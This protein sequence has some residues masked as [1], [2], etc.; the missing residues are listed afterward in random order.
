MTNQAA[1]KWT[2]A[3]FRLHPG[4]MAPEPHWLVR[5]LYGRVLLASEL[6]RVKPELEFSVYAPDDSL[7]PQVDEMIDR[8]GLRKWPRPS[9]CREQLRAFALIL[10][11]FWALELSR[12]FPK[13]KGA[14]S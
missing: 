4:H 11:M 6:R 12:P 2:R 1:A 9:G 14:F 8:L 10:R 13:W 7:L 3:D 5:H